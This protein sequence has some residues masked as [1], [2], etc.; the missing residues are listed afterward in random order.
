M[1]V[2][3]AASLTVD[4]FQ[5]LLAGSPII[6]LP[7]QL[8]VLLDALDRDVQGRRHS[9]PI[10]VHLPQLHC[11]LLRPGEK[12]LHVAA[13]G[14]AGTGVVPWTNR[15]SLEVMSRLN[16]PDGLALL[17][18]SVVKE[19]AESSLPM[20]LHSRDGGHAQSILHHIG[21]HL[22]ELHPSAASKN[23]AHPLVEIH[24]GFGTEEISLLILHQVHGLLH[25]QNAVL[26]GSGPAGPPHLEGRI[27]R[28]AGH[29]RP[30][31]DDKYFVR[32]VTLVEDLLPWIQEPTENT[33]GELLYS[34]PR[35][36]FNQGALVR[37][38]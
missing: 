31:S 18:L 3:L 16:S 38:R 8:I 36:S 28:L 26:P 23:R 34:V 20:V 21:H 2:P 14:C 12:A 13:D 27:K 11:A 33:A 17:P 4:F 6:L 24:Y 30:S 5:T 25:H 29:A 9:Y 15:L 35:D 19:S 7:L 22:N 32:G 37:L 10:I 1:D